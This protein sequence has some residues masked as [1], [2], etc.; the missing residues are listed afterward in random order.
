MT[1][2][3]LTRVITGDN[4]VGELFNVVITPTRRTLDVSG[5]QRHNMPLTSKRDGD[6]IIFNQNWLIKIF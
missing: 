2:S 1:T 4:V 3:V 5:L 6:N